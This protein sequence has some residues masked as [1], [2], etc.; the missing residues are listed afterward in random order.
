MAV[1]ITYINPGTVGTFPPT[2]VQMLPLSRVT[3]IVAFAA[4]TDTTA[5]ITHNMNIPLASTPTQH[6]QNSGSPWVTIAAN[7]TSAGTVAG[8][9]S[10]TRGTNIL[11]LNKLATVAGTNCTVEVNIDR[12]E[13][14]L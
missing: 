4:D 11:T 3:V 10:F 14:L 6:G 8:V 2:A 5:L 13:P 9:I 1:T 12:Y 7:A